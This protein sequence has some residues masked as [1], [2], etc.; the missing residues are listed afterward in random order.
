[1]GYLWARSVN[2]ELNH[3]S[4]NVSTRNLFDLGAAD[5]RAAAPRDQQD[6]VAIARAVRDRAAQ[7]HRAA[8]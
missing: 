5:R 8:R 2:V 7:L 6:S 4:E 1:M 3:A